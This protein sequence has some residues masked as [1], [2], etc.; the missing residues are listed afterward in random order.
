MRLTILLVL[1]LAML[2]PATCAQ[3][4]VFEITPVGSAMKFD[5]EASVAITGKF[6]KWSWLTQTRFSP[7]PPVPLELM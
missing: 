1:I 3:V 5:V 6:D 4:P 2:P 7:T